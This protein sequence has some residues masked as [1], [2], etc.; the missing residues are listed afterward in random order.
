MVPGILQHT[1]PRGQTSHVLVLNSRGV[2]SAY[3]GQDKHPT[4]PEVCG[5]LTI[6]TGQPEYDPKYLIP[7]SHLN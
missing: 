2:N 7:A 3:L 5:A 1:L 6:H 4:T